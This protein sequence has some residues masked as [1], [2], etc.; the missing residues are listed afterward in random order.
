M[1]GPPLRAFVADDDD[2]AGLDLVV[3]DALTASS[4][5]SK[6]RAGPVNFRIDSST[7]AV[8][9]MQPSRARLPY[10][11]ARPPSLRERMLER[12]G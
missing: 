12:R 11:T 7:P 9:T 2:V 8:F 6:T 5:L 3:E 10:S 1:P 4:W